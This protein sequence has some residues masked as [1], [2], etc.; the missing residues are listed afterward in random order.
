MS[1]ARRPAE[2]RADT[3]ADRRVF[4]VAG[5]FVGFV[6]SFGASYQTVFTL[7]REPVEFRGGIMDPLVEFLLRVAINMTSIAIILWLAVA[8]RLLERRLPLLLVGS[9][10]NVVLAIA[11]RSALHL[12]FGLQEYGD[13]VTMLRSSAVAGFVAI[14]VVIAAF[15]VTLLNRQAREAERA[16]RHAM[17]RAAEALSELQ[18]EELRV[19]RDVADMLH[20]TMQQRL[21]VLRSTI[22]SAL[23][24]LAEAPTADATARAQDRLRTVRRELDEMRENELRALSASLYPEGL[25]RGLVPALRAL[26][27]RVPA[28][29]AVRFDVDDVPTPDTLGQEERLL[30]VRVAEEGVSNALRHGD[31]HEI[32]VR[33][34]CADDGFVVEVRNRGVPPEPGIELSGL[35]RL[36]SRLQDRGGSLELRSEAEGAT[37]RAV[38]PCDCAAAR[39]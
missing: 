8:M 30:L 16:Q 18:Q 25:D 3:R 27:A 22:D 20:G 9:V 29:I 31:A 39:N 1:A 35:A 2:S 12:C 13:T 36:R 6:F 10:V 26:T 28:S 11:V 33:L 38:L 37:L 17:I 21:V 23:E 5:L 14:F 34:T 32:E 15:T 7:N 4:L 24:D 19:R